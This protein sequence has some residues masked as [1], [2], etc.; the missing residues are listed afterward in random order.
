LAV[1]DWAIMAKGGF[2]KLVSL[3]NNAVLNECD[4]AEHLAKDD[5]REVI[6]MYLED[7]REGQ[8]REK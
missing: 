8:K 5:E 4:L 7:V 1:I 6:T 2:S 3:G